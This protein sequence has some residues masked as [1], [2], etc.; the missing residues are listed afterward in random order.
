[1]FPDG[2]VPICKKCILEQIDENDIAS[3]KRILR[4]IDK[5]YIHTLW[6]S[7]LHSKND[8]FGAYMKNINSLP[9]YKGLTYDDSIE[10]KQSEK[11]D[12]N[13][14]EGKKSYSNSDFK[15]TEKIID[16]WGFGYEPEEYQQFERKYNKLIHN[17][18]E[19]TA[20][21]TEGLISYIRFR[22][23]EELATASGNVKEAKEWGALASGSAKDA[24]LN[25]SQLSKSDISGGV[26]VVSQLF[27]AV[28]TEVSIIPLLPKILEQPMDDVDMVIWATVNYNRRLEDKEKVSY[29]EIWN[30]YD[31][32][33][34][35]FFQSKGY[36]SEEKER[37]KASRNN[38]FRDLNEVYIE[39]LYD[40]D[41]EMVEGGEEDGELQE[42]S[43]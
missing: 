18:G 21:H 9:Q 7:S 3:V 24:K 43:E 35:E 14:R 8:T 22:V 29:R 6:E 40:D 31:E 12:S 30:F 13:E 20:L 4:Q 26:D 11:V 28:E 2:K 32:M 19:K 15:I 1:M 41:D 5:P 33:L 37:F 16:K 42:F 23:K 17:Y 27:E 34:D 39:P 36:N 10:E 38:V 25:V